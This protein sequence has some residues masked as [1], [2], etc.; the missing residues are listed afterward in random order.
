MAQSAKPP[1]RD[2]TRTE[3]LFLLDAL[4]RRGAFLSLQTPTGNRQTYK[5]QAP[6]VRSGVMPPDYAP[7]LV[8]EAIEKAWIVPRGPASPEGSPTFVLSHAGRQIVKS[9]RSHRA[10]S[11][12]TQASSTVRALPKSSGGQR[13]AHESPLDWLRRRTD[14]SGR[15]LLDAAQYEAGERLRTDLTLAGMTPR[16]TMS[17]SGIPLGSSARRRGGLAPGTITDKALAAGQRAR[18]ALA[19]VGPE[20]AEILVDVFGHLKGL[21][22]IAVAEGW[23]KR[24]AKLLLQRALTALG[25]HYGLIPPVAVEQTLSRRLRHW[26]A[27][28]YRPTLARWVRKPDSS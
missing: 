19:A 9:A 1:G 14:T 4:A 10:Q 17:W 20:H 27:D 3:T 16:T 18:S 7:S 2:T 6:G 15:P 13:V 22:A 28:D 23:P 24:S 21:E 5:V 8:R 25:R 12:A 26:G 11:R